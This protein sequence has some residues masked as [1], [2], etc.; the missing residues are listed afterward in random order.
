[1][2]VFGAMQH[3][4]LM[5]CPKAQ[6]PRTVLRHSIN[7]PPFAEVIQW[8]TIKVNLHSCAH[9]LIIHAL[10]AL[11]HKLHQLEIRLQLSSALHHA[12]DWVE[13]FW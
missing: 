1:M 4:I 11:P 5:L 7:Q 9:V 13:R 2:E 12:N 10:L 3:S 8:C 6:G